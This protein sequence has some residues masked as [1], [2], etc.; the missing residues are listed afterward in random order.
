NVVV[1][2]RYAI[3]VDTLRNPRRYV[4][5]FFFHSAA[6]VSTAFRIDWWSVGS[7]MLV[8]FG[9]VAS[10]PI[11]FEYASIYRTRAS[12]SYSSYPGRTNDMS[13]RTSAGPFSVRT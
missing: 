2:S 4:G 5:Y 7:S 9:S 6:V 13:S 3:S 11:D 1:G 12:F 8:V 10:A